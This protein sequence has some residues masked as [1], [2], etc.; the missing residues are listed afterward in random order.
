MGCKQCFEGFRLD[1]KENIFK[2]VRF[3]ITIIELNMSW[4]CFSAKEISLSALDISAPN[5]TLYFQ[6]HKRNHFMN[7]NM[8]FQVLMAIYSPMITLFSCYYC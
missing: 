4:L 5:I 3:N 1:Y 2:S 6:L 8:N 7:H